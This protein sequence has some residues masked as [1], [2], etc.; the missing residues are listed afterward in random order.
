LPPGRANHKNKVVETGAKEKAYD[1]I[2]KRVAEGRQD[3]LSAPDRGVGSVQARA[4]IGEYE[5]LSQ[6]VF[7][8]LKLGLLHGR[9]SSSVKTKRRCDVPLSFGRG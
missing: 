2:R 6:E 7:P 1:F 5:F 8:T 3:L 4:A 9:M